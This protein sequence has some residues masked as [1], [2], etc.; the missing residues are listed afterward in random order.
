VRRSAVGEGA[1]VA[2]NETSGALA[3]QLKDEE[4]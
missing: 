1:D 4:A 3:P 2:G